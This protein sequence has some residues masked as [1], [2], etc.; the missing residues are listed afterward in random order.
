MIQKLNYDVINHYDLLIDENND[1]ARDLLPLQEYMN[2]WDGQEFIEEL[3]LSPNKTVLEI[4][5]CTGRLA[6][7]VCGNCKS[8][9][10]IDL[11]PKTISRAKESLSLFDN[12][13]LICIDFL[14]YEFDAKFD[15]IYSSLTFMHI[16]DKQEAIRKV[17]D[18][19]NSNGLFVLS[20]SKSQDRILNYGD[21][22]IELYPD[23]LEQITTLLAD[24]NLTIKKK[25]ETEF[26]T[27]LVTVKE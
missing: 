20:I 19:L 7:K 24:A 26:A 27:I 17:A 3:Q 23:T 18:L 5:V 16:E 13:T 9:V 14:V 21:R 22:E 15:C 12:A 10:G 2:K 25:F 1:P 11:S 6:L 4:G 8:F